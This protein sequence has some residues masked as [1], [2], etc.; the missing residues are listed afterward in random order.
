MILLSV[1]TQLPFDRLVRAVDDWARASGRTDVVAQIGPSNYTPHTLRT[2]SFLA[3]DAFLALQMDAALHISHAGMGSILTAMEHGKPIII[4][5][6]DFERGEHRNGHQAATA[7]R[8]AGTPGVHIAMDVDTL[9]D[10]LNHMDRL[11]AATGISPHAPEQFTTRLRNYLIEG[12]R[13]AK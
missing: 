7:K 4:M 11:V 10:Q 8:F 9:T 13:P 1:G 5:P 2:F 12:G 6:R 3:Q